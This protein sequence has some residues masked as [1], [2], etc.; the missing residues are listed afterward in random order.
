LLLGL[1]CTGFPGTLGFIGSELLVEGAVL[2]FPVLGF[3][4]VAAGALTGLAVLRMYFSLFCGRRDEGSPLPLLP[5]E[6]V[7]FAFLA[8][9]L[10]ATGIAPGPVVATA[11]SAGE[12]LF[13]LR[14]RRLRPSPIS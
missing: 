13:E 4:V 10:L 1:A 14:E 2:A 12:Q 6:A 8:A 5:R 9:L 7:T 11:S 3:F